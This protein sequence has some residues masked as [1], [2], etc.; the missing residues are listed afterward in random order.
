MAAKP[1]L[2]NGEMVRAILDG[3]KTQTRR[4]MKLS[5][6]VSYVSYKSRK[7]RQS[8]I[9]A[10]APHKIGDILYIREAFRLHCG[11]DE[12]GC[13]GDICVCPPEG[14]LIYRAD[15]DDGESKW[16]PSVHMPKEHARIFLKVTNVRCE[17]IEN[18][19]SYDAACEGFDSERDFIL[20]WKRTY[21][22]FD[23]SSFAW[24]YEFNRCER[25]ENFLEAA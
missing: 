21:L 19:S 22:L 4:P 20:A 5:D 24:V 10:I 17:R 3:R 2:F 1:I 15:M 25:P 8:V 14:T 6:A 12:C 11:T 13:G 23:E 18:M 9:D 16:K 7:S